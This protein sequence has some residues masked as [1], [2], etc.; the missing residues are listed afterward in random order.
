MS[1]AV[2]HFIVGPEDETYE[3]AVEPHEVLDMGF[4]WSRILRSDTISTSSWEKPSDVTLAQAS[5]FSGA[6]TSIWPQFPTGGRFALVNQ[7][8]TAGGRTYRRQL[9]ARRAM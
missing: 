3:L 8:I 5:S 7:I 9:T 4:D 2:R 1:R 6:R